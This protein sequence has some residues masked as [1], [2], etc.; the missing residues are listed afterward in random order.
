MHTETELLNPLSDNR[1][2]TMKD[3]RQ[4]KRREDK[5]SGHM[6]VLGNRRGQKILIY[7]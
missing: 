4:G 2:S 5:F 1:K 6:Y 3:L 7:S